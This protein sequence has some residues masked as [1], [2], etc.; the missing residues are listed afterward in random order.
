MFTLVHSFLETMQCSVLYVYVE[1]SCIFCEFRNFSY[2]ILKHTQSSLLNNTLSK[3]ITK[4]VFEEFVVFLIF[5]IAVIFLD[6]PSKV[7]WTIFGPRQWEIGLM[8][9]ICISIGPWP[10]WILSP[11]APSQRL[12]PARQRLKVN[13]YRLT[14]RSWVRIPSAR[15]RCKAIL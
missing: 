8:L 13:M 10:A 9:T 6:Q 11:S 7:L 5:F 4:A 15:G 14:P 1:N 3:K 12:S 2:F